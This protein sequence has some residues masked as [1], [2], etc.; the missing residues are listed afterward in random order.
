VQEQAWSQFIAG[1]HAELLEMEVSRSNA[2]VCS[3]DR[4]LYICLFTPSTGRGWSIFGTK[5]EEEG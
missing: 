5:E 2:I 4:D 1:H 3:C